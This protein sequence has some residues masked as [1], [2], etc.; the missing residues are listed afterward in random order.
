MK[1][2]GKNIDRQ[3]DNSMYKQTLKW[4]LDFT[5]LI[6]ALLLL[7]AIWANDGGLA[8]EASAAKEFW[9]YAVAGW[10]GIVIAA[11]CWLKGIRFR[12]VQTD[13]WVLVFTG[14]LLANYYF[15]GSVAETKAGLAVLLAITYFY[16]R[17]L[18]STSKEAGTVLTIALIFIGLTEAIYGWCQLYGVASS[19][20]S[21]FKLTGSFFNPGPYSGFLAILLPVALYQLLETYPK[22]NR[23]ANIKQLLR[24][25]G[26]IRNYLILLLSGSCLLAIITILPAGM[27]RSA[28][29]AG[30]AGCGVVVAGHFKTIPKINRFYQT[31]KKRFILCFILACITV[32]TIGGGIYLLKKD[33]AD[34]RLLMWKISAQAIRH[35]PGTGGGIGCFSGAYGK[36]QA[37][38]FAESQPGDQREQEERVAGSPEYGFNEYLQI[39]IEQGVIGLLLFLLLIG[40]AL[41]QGVKFPDNR[42]AGV[43]GGLVAFLVFACFSYPFSVLPLCIVFVFLLAMCIGNDKAASPAWAVRNFFFLL[44]IPAFLTARHG[45]SKKEA[46][47]TWATEKRYFTMNI[48]EKTVDN[49]RQLYPQ[50]KDQAAFLFE[51]GQCLSKT[52]Q[53]RESNWVL[54]E[55]TR[56]SCDPMLY[57]IIGK[58]YQAMQ[59]YDQAAEAF[60]YAAHLV[61]HRLYPLYLLTNLYF[62]SGQTA[63]ALVTA[64]RFLRKEPKVM[65]TAVREMKAEISD[66]IKNLETKKP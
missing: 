64:G 26:A 22:I 16:F 11:G 34:G 51:Y 55:G 44:L 15:T 7:S 18:R 46:Y 48:F 36:A 17:L 50:L 32:C 25:P 43:A 5:L 62:E 35:Q 21:L 28:W 47:R 63:K 19:N 2:N 65:S 31:R 54:Y 60:Q 6:T 37:T 49:Y 33:S 23:I 14:Y 24:S 1:G 56:L 61:P 9:F 29:L 27:S 58:N 13:L 40:S 45:E 10:T 12:F 57:N 53:Y 52:G 59:Q 4:T 39:T 38:Y 20:H 30:V 41:W 42:T 3:D 8:Q 66:K